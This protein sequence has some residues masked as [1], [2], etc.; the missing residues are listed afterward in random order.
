MRP[1]YS[2][3]YHQIQ[4]LAP[5]RA[6]L[7][8][9]LASLSLLRRRDS[10]RHKDLIRSLRAVLISPKNGYLNELFLADRVWICQS[11]TIEEANRAY[12]A[13]LLVH[14]L[15]HLRQ[16][17]AGHSTTGRRAERL[18]YLAQR[19]FLRVLSDTLGIAWLD[20]QYEEQWWKTR[21][22]DLRAYRHFRRLLADY[23]GRRLTL[24]PLRLRV[25]KRGLPRRRAA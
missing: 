17:R 16:K 5:S 20:K 6:L 22:A 9:V 19:S 3:R 23:K 21:K 18:A 24:L 12:L 7:R 8:R 10:A 14:E 15:H 13:S 25:R 11:S 4:L 2:H 1:F